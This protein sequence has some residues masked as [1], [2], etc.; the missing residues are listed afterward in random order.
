MVTIAHLVKKHIDCMPFLQ[1]AMFKEIISYGNLADELQPAIE[2]E[3]GKKVKTS[4]VIMALRRY[5]ESLKFTKKKKFD[6]SSEII[7]RTGLIDIAVL[8]SLNLFGILDKIYKIV[9]YEK[10]ELLNIIQGTNE[11]AI[12]TNNKYEKKVIDIL[13]DEKIINVEKNLVSISMS[14]P[15]EFIHTPGIIFA[16][17]RKLSWEN[18]NI[19]EIVSTFTELTFII[20]KKDLTR[21]YNVLNEVVN[22]L[23]F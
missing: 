14:Y 11:V 22:G 13:K 4:A 18:I 7:M 12:I 17:V 1:E 8:K 10:G 15:Q 21:A 19:Y 23:N 3:L 6:F 5:A 16:V 2:K 9:D 20:N